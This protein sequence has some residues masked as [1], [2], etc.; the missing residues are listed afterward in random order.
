MNQPSEPKV[1][2]PVVDANNPERLGSVIEVTDTVFIVDWYGEDEP[3]GY[4]RSDWG[5]AVKW[6]AL[7]YAGS[8][9]M[10][11]LVH[12]LGERKQHFVFEDPHP[13]RGEHEVFKYRMPGGI[14]EQGLKIYRD[15]RDRG[16]WF[17]IEDNQSD[18]MVLVEWEALR[19]LGIV[20]GDERDRAAEQAMKELL[21]T[22]PIERQAMKEQE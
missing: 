13:W 6:R 10:D 3:R 11:Q 20:M 22:Y 5:K 4:D 15:G 12:A 14:I 7:A 16:L 8:N 18:N 9:P 2:R 1:R 17:A 21:A 19:R